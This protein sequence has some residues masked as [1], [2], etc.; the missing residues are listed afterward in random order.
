MRKIKRYGPEG[1]IYMYIYKHQMLNPAL[2]FPPMRRKEGK[3][4]CAMNIALGGIFI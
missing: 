2:F 1:T 3:P 4:T